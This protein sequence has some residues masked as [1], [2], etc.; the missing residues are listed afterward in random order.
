[1]A[2]ASRA[3]TITDIQETPSLIDHD[4]PMNWQKKRPEIPIITSNL[5]S[6]RFRGNSIPKYFKTRP[7][8]D[9]NTP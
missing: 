7:S 3:Y 4:T 5:F 9:S 1:M 8:F 6:Q 2:D